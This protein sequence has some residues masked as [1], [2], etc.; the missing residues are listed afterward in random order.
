MKFKPLERAADDLHVLAGLEVVGRQAAL[1]GDGGG[2]RPQVGDDLGGQAGGHAWAVGLVAAKADE[3]AA[4]RVQ[5]DRP[6]SRPPWRRGAQR[7]SRGRERARLK[8]CARGRSTSA[9]RP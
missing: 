1:R 9:D 6:I 3:A 2:A 7:G 4:G 8:L 5:L